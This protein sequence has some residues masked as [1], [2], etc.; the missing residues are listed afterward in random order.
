MDARM[1]M[2][3]P[4]AFSKQVCFTVHAPLDNTYRCWRT[5]SRANADLLTRCQKLLQI[6]II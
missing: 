1:A 3:G 6:V 2:A 4:L 5:Q